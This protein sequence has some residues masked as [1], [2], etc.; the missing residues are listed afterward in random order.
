MVA[1]L[2]FLTAVYMNEK[3]P[4]P[5]RMKAAIEAAQYVHPKLAAIASIQADGDFAARL[6]R[7][8]T[9]SRAAMAPRFI[10]GTARPQARSPEALVAALAER[11]VAVVPGGVMLVAGAK[12]VGN[13]LVSPARSAAQV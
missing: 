5:T 13:S 6:D 3:L 11:G 2:E 9:A 4:L 7:A 10:E 8:I 12:P 1:P